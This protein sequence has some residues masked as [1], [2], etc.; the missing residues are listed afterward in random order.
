MKDFRHKRWI[1]TTHFNCFLIHIANNKGSL[2]SFPG[3][4]LLKI[5]ENHTFL[6][7]YPKGSPPIDVLTVLN[8]FRHW[9]GIIKIC[10]NCFLIHIATTRGS[11]GSFPGV[12]LPKIDKNHTFLPCYPKRSPPIDILTKS[13][14]F[15]HKTGIITTHFNC[16]L[17]HIASTRGSVGSLPAGILPK[18][19]KIYTFFVMLPKVITPNRRSNSIERLR[20]QK[21][22]HKNPFQLF[23]DS[24]S[25]NQGVTEVIFGGS[26]APNRQKP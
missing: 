23:Y 12:I 25:H 16:F 18:I 4:I 9:T 13:N 21:K 2:G 5:D 15:R 19:D 6:P 3:V 22:N 1:I 10:F 11:L 24:Y 26:C 7:C 20:A 17:I 14:D 8:Y